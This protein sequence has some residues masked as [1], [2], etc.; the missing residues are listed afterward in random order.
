[1]K[2]ILLGLGATA[3]VAGFVIGSSWSAI[4]R[5][6]AE[7]IRK[8]LGGNARVQV[9]AE[10]D[11]LLGTVLGRVRSVSIE[12]SNFSVDGMPFFVEPGLSKSGRMGSLRFALRDFVIRDLPVRELAAEIPENRFP[13]G[14]LRSGVVRLSDSGEGKGSVTITESG[15]AQYMRRR[16]AQILL[17]VDVEFSKHKVFARGQAALGPIRK[18]F[19]IIADLEIA[20][21]RQLRISRQVV[22]MDGVRIRDGSD[23][24]LIDSLNPVLDIDRDLGLAGGFDMQRL[25]ISEGSAIIFGAARIPMRPASQGGR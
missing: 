21:P 13:L 2:L 11:G 18:R 9:T 19:E 24:R 5:A 25:K 4:E 6:A 12:A 22:F 3:A 10:S 1:M 16:F 20:T 7:D 14:L 15:L 17:E 23:A 8:Q